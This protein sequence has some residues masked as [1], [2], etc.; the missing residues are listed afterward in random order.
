[1]KIKE[2]YEKL[3][4]CSEPCPAKTS[5]IKE[6][7]SQIIL[8]NRNYLQINQ[9]THY[10]NKVSRSKEIVVLWPLTSIFSFLE[11][12]F[13]FSTILLFTLSSAGIELSTF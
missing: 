11:L 1:M 4:F 3:L 8:G 2:T 9:I 13:N 5:I 12:M 6:W 10:F 7:V